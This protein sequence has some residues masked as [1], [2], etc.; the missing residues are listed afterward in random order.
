MQ[1]RY[2]EFMMKKTSLLLLAALVGAVG[3]AEAL[4]GLLP[5]DAKKG[6]FHSFTRYDFTL[7]GVKTILVA[8]EKAA[9]G[10]P[11]IW[12]A[13]F[14]GHQPQTDV[15]LLKHGFHVAY[16]EVGNLYGSPQAV[17]RWNKA[18]AYF[19]EKLGFSKKPVL[20][21]MS[22]GGLI[23]F[24]WA[25][26]NPDKVAAIYA[27]APVCDFK[28][29]PRLKSAGDW[30]RCKAAYGFKTEEEA[31]AYADNPKDNLEALARAGVPVLAVCGATDTVV[32]M[33]KNI[34]VLAANYRKAGGN[35]RV[36]SKPENGHHPHSLYDPA[37]IVDFAREWA[38]GESAMIKPRAGLGN[39]IQ[40][41]KSGKAT[42]AFIG[43]S[44]VEMNGFRPRTCEGLKKLYPACAFTFLDAG[45]SSTCSDTGAF[46]LQRDILGKGKVDLLFVEFATNDS[47]D[48]TYPDWE[49]SLR[50]MEGIVRKARKANP[51]MDIV[52][53]YTANEQAT[54]VYMK[55]AC[56]IAAD[57]LVD[58]T[59]SF[60]NSR[61]PAQLPSPVAE[62]ERVACHYRLPSINFGFEVAER[63][64]YGEFDWKAFGGVH[65]SPMGNQIYAD[66]I[67]NLVRGQMDKPTDVA[68]AMPARPI[69][70]FNYENARFIDIAEAKIVKGWEIKIPDW[71]SLP[72]YKRGRFTNIPM[73]CAEEP[74]AE[75]T[76]A[77]TGRVV[78]L[79]LTAG[80]DAGK[81]EYKV[82]NSE[83]KTADL[84]YCHS[85]SLHYPYTLTLASTLSKGAH[86]LTLRVAQDANPKSKGHAVRIMA[87]TGN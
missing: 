31:L 63:M 38:V 50:A 23:I 33:A 53:V 71:K 66:M 20:E 19:T 54:A 46:R 84:Y 64:R 85:G 56:P 74:G 75:L 73:L 70:P 47:G 4:G 30:T 76:L 40:A 77:F 44:I 29:W 8:P 83:W 14:F 72:G 61:G 24:N 26:R 5:N 67:L 34:D 81:V 32:E 45:I 28:D 18:Y 80:P 17:E 36:I 79:Y 87:F 25:K 52:L 82:D 51:K 15:A 22:R 55:N 58:R 43:G 41:F 69:S 37:V 39:A 2:K 13:R 48:G 21:G 57:M 60:D 7:E 12:R 27:D 16:V 62:F 10:K 86:T 35:I 6:A 11:W 42:V 65:P 3:F 59:A 49:K 1:K 68:H 9:A 78:G